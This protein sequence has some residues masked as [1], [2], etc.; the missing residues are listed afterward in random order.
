MTGSRTDKADA[1]STVSSALQR[2][3]K[4]LAALGVIAWQSPAKLRDSGGAL[5][6]DLVL[7]AMGDL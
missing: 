1:L 3:A 5:A 7:R 4:P 2:N 6:R